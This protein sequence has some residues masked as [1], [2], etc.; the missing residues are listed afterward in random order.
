MKNCSPTIK[1]NAIIYIAKYI[2]KE[3][4]DN[5][6]IYH[7]NKKN[8]ETILNNY[9]HNENIL[10]PISTKLKI[11]ILKNIELIENKIQQL[12]DTKQALDINNRYCTICKEYFDT[13]EQLKNHKISINHLRQ[14]NIYIKNINIVLEKENIKNKQLKEQIEKKYNKLYYNFI[15]LETEYNYLL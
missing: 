7:L 3:Q 9:I 6:N 12:Y 10:L 11:Y 8:I 14:E 1:R 2:T 5:L 13:Q 15:K 4:T